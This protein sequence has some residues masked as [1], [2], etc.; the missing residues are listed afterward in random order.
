MIRNHLSKIINYSN[1][2][3]L[4]LGSINRP[5]KSRAMS[6]EVKKAL[7]AQPDGDTIFGKILRKEIPCQFIYEDEK[8]VAFHGE[9]FIIIP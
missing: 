1:R 7:A 6:D 9:F 8:A 3:F 2:S 4:S 5:I